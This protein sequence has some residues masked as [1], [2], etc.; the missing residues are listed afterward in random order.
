MSQNYKPIEERDLQRADI[1]RNV[2]P[3]SAPC[4]FA[5]YAHTLLNILMSWQKKRVIQMKNWLNSEI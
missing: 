5:F 3:M 1:C 2:R 4:G